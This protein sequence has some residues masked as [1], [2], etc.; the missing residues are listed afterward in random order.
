MIQNIILYL[1][2][3]VSFSCFTYQINNYL[4][5]KNPQPDFKSYTVSEL[6]S[7]ALFWPLF[8]SIFIVSFIK[9]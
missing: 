8:L 7:I 2:W 4:N 1:L 5:E 9:S 3:G 6:L